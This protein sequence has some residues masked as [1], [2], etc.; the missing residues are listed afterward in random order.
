MGVAV[1]V[2]ESWIEP[3]G[4]AFA[5]AR[6]TAQEMYGDPHYSGTIAAKADFLVI[7]DE[8]VSHSAAEALAHRL[9]AEHDP[10]IEDKWG[11]AG[12]IP[13]EGGGWVFFGR[14]ST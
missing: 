14:A 1:F 3:V 7:A 9:I 8:P 10:R 4:E 5:A 12:A 2:D 6:E 11:P 13:V